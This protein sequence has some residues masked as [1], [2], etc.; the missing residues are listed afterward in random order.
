MHSR[1]P[2]CCV[3]AKQHACVG[4]GLQLPSPGMDAL[5]LPRGWGT[6]L[7][8]WLSC[9]WLVQLCWLGE[10]CQ[11][12]Q[13]LSG[14]GSGA[15]FRRCGSAACA[16]GRLG[17]ESHPGSCGSRCSQTV[18]PSFLLETWPSAALSHPRE[19]Q[20]RSS[21][22]SP[23]RAR[24]RQ[25]HPFFDSRYLFSLP[26]SPANS[27]PRTHPGLLCHRLVSLPVPCMLPALPQLHNSPSP[28]LTPAEPRFGR[29]LSHI[30]QHTTRQHHA[31]RSAPHLPWAF[32]TFPSCVNLRKA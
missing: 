23:A 3:C 4:N 10:C 12:R 29:S 20:G 27:L 13:Q 22:P 19:G 30:A 1:D 32:K 21:A 14:A 5:A 25:P 8:C 15:A 28:S 24:P 16:Q 7:G 6:R 17:L 9:W 31:A 18:T 2:N 11:G 26:V